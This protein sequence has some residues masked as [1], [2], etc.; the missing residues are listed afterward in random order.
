M[1]ILSSTPARIAETG[2]GASTCAGGSQV[3]TGKSGVLMPNPTMSASSTSP[4]ATPAPGS[5]G[6]GAHVE[7]QRRRRQRQDDDPDQ[8]QQRPG[9][10]VDEELQHR[11]LRL[12]MAPAADQEVHPDEAQVEEEVEG[13]EVEGE[14]ELQRHA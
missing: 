12:A 11:V 9:K 3:C 1:P 2:T 8:D 4:D 5:G 7:S 10:R 6:S 13:H 14:K